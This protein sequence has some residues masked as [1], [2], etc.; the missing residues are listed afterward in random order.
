MARVV[1]QGDGRAVVRANAAQRA[2]QDILRAVHGRRD[3][4][5]AHVLRHAEGVPAG[6]I[7]EQVVGQRQLS[8]RARAGGDH[9]VERRLAGIEQFIHGAAEREK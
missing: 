1:T 6:L 2:Q 9:L 3:P 7:A 5:H 8:L 4:A